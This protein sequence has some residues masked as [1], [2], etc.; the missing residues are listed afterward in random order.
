[1]HTTVRQYVLYTTHDVKHG[2]DDDG[3]DG[4]GGGGDGLMVDV[5]QNKFDSHVFTMT[6]FSFE[7]ASNYSIYAVWPKR[8]SKRISYNKLTITFFMRI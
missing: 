3:G 2:I 7:S 4:D 5:C 8:F 1:M 6:R